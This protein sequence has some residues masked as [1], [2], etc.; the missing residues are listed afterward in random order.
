[1]IHNVKLKVRDEE[2]WLTSVSYGYHIK[3]SDVPDIDKIIQLHQEVALQLGSE[4][5]LPIEGGFLRLRFS[6]T[7]HDQFFYDWLFTSMM[8]EGG[9]E[10]LQ[11]EVEAVSRISF[12]DCYCVGVEEWMSADGAPMG[13]ELLLSP[14]ILKKDA[15]VHEKVWKITDIH[16][17]TEEVKVEE[18]DG[19]KKK[20]VEITDAYWIDDNGQQI[21]EL[22]IDYPITLYVVTEN[23]I[24]GKT[25]HLHFEDKDQDGWKV[26]DCSGNIDSN[27]IIVLENFKLETVKEESNGTND[28]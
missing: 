13:I 11:N 12:W 4:Q 24:V 26:A 5:V 23:F 19:D 28:N 16:G 22:N 10:F 25:V 6:S 3:F 7:D 2:R 14:A 17:N 27:G 1:M 20:I 15:P 8:E 21:R 18:E 9:I